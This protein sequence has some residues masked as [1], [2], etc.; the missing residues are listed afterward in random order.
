MY[1]SEY[2]SPYAVSTG[3]A[4]YPKLFSIVRASRASASGGGLERKSRSEA[5][6]RSEI[7]RDRNRRPAPRPSRPAAIL[8]RSPS[9]SPAAATNSGD[10]VSPAASAAAKASPPN[11]RRPRGRWRDAP[12]ATDRDSA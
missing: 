12:K 9:L 11:P 10:G 7:P 5:P 1:L 6:A 8:G 3:F 4:A 2:N